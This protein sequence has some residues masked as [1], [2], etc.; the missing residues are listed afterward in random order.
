MGGPKFP[1]AMSQHLNRFFNPVQPVGPNQIIT[2]SALTAIHE[3]LGNALGEPGDGILVARPIY[4]RFE[5]DFGNTNSLRIVYAD[6]SEIDPFSSEIV[7]RLQT[8]LDNYASSSK[9]G[10]DS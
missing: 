6:S 2:S 1:V 4:G 3:M 9:I 8:A 7:P 10:G 5:L